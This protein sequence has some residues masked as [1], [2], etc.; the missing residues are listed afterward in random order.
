VG[1]STRGD[2]L[3][4]A[5]LVRKVLLPPVIAVVGAACLL[6]AV[7]LTIANG[8]RADASNPL[9]AVEDHGRIVDSLSV[10]LEGTPAARDIRLARKPLSE[11]RRQLA[12]HPYFE[13]YARAARRFGVPWVL[14]ASVHYQ[15]TGFRKAPSKL[16]ANDVVMS[17]ASQLHEFNPDGGLGEGA[18]H[19]V[20]KRYGAKPAGTLSA[21]MVIERARAWRVLGTI[22]QP[23]RG[24][25]ATPAA[26]V[27]GG[28]GYFGCPRPGHL[29]N[30]VDFLAPTGTP[31][32]AADAGRVALVETIG[33]SG[34]YGNFVCIQHRPHLA[35]CYAHLSAVAA[36]V[37]AGAAV[38]RGQVIGLVG[39][40]G[41]SSA[42]HLHFEVRRGPAECQACAVDPLPML[43]GDVPQNSVPK[44]LRLAGEHARP[45]A[46]RAVAASQEP[47]PVT[48][49]PVPAA[50]VNPAPAA[51]PAT[52]TATVPPA[53]PQ[54]RPAPAPVATK[55]P[56]AT[57]PPAAKAKPKPPPPAN[58]V[59]DYTP[60]GGTVDPNSSGGA[61]APTDSPAPSGG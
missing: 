1:V 29:H 11:R 48:Q 59:I 2:R 20:A 61:H 55:R 18:M 16:V 53:R 14:V 24:E 52:P 54:R 41:S 22:P 34:G 30:G 42:P 58:P 45:A 27:V 12:K 43:S 8:S 10:E 3:R 28:C 9:A 35:T 38:R 21:A 33:E 57:T 15:E 50:P 47:T 44:I 36:T 46:P 32:H 4:P 49:A 7:A 6:G 23:G 5:V 19:A 37:R 17:I 13:L 25:L 60:P 31:I 26:G 40:T 51:Q 56:A 39:S